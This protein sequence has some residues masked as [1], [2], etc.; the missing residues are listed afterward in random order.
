METSLTYIEL[1]PDGILSAG[2]S[3]LEDPDRRA[4]A[5]QLIFQLG[6]YQHRPTFV[7]NDLYSDLNAMDVRYSID[8]ETFNDATEGLTEEELMIVRNALTD[9][10][11]LVGGDGVFYQEEIFNA[12]QQILLRAKKNVNLALHTE[13]MVAI[14]RLA[15]VAGYEVIFD[16][17]DVASFRWG[18][19]QDIFAGSQEAEYMS[20]SIIAEGFAYKIILNDSQLTL[21]QSNPI[22]QAMQDVFPEACSV[23][24]RIDTKRRQRISNE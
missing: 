19:F 14:V 7:F 10:K 6:V 5:N 16:A 9:M 12:I 11:E 4:K 3:I 22:V 2:S 23:T 17:T 15:L 8:E 13:S 24:L 18:I 20:T 21:R 1:F